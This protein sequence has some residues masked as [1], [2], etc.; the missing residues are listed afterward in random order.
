MIHTGLKLL[1]F[2]ANLGLS[3][4]ADYRGWWGIWLASAAA[5]IWTGPLLFKR[6]QARSDEQ[7]EAAKQ[8]VFARFDA[9]QAAERERTGQSPPHPADLP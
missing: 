5:S 2:L 9:K 8:L 7:F 6:W 1:L 4:Y 3:F